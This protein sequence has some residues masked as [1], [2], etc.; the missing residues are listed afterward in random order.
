MRRVTDQTAMKVRRK[1][2]RMAIKV[3]KHR[4]II[5]KSFHKAIRQQPQ[6]IH[7]QQP[8]KANVED[9]K[10]NILL[11]KGQK[12]D[13]GSEHSS[14]VSVQPSSILKNSTNINKKIRTAN[15]FQFSDHR[16]KTGPMYDEN[17]SKNERHQNKKAYT[18]AAGFMANKEAFRP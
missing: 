12:I 13:N 1:V 6:S 14:I 4:K 5:E 8:I 3:I 7:D 9:A 18:A 16:G 2:T 15:R 10:Q 11:E 17:D